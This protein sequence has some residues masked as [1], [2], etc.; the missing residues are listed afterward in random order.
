MGEDFLV[1]ELDQEWRRLISAAPTTQLVVSVP[2]DLAEDL[3]DEP[4]RG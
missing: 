1:V 2:A 3:P 4:F